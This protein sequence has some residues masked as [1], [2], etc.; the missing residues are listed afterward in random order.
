MVAVEKPVADAA[1]TAGSRCPRGCGGSM[2]YWPAMDRGLPEM[3]CSLCS[4]GS[5]M[6]PD[7]IPTPA[8]RGV[9]RFRY[10]GTLA[11]LI[12]RVVY[13]TMIPGGSVVSRARYE[14]RCVWSCKGTM[15]AT[16]Q[17]SVRREGSR[18][19]ACD[20]HTGHRVWL[21][22]NDFVWVE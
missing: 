3:V 1:L 6:S 11:R 14:F 2:I 12:G 17:E 18:R 22:V 9:T 19:Y 16:I 8:L 20:W 10:V 21:D 15:R 13:A 4:R 5:E 7:T